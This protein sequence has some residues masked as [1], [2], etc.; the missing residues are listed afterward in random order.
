PADRINPVP[1]I[2]IPFPPGVQTPLSP[3]G[4][5]LQTVW[6]YCDLGFQVRD[7]TKYNLDVFQLSWAPIGGQVINDFFENFEIRLSH[8]FRL[9]DESINGLL[10]PKYENSGLVRPFVGNILVDPLSPQKI[11]HARTLG[12]QVRNADL[13]LAS[14]GTVMMPFPLNRILPDPVT[15][16]WRDT[17]VL[18]KGGPNGPGIPL[19]IESGGPLF[20]EAQEGTVARPDEVPSFGLPLLMEYR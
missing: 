1:S 8:S 18:A 9:P 7:E 13:F 12:Y 10:L 20:L 15:Y 16:T 17:A 3:L 2:M 14:S 11:V 4:S 19:D 5:K 6:R